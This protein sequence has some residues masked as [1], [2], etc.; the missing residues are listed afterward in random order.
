MFLPSPQVDL[1][2][3]AAVAAVLT[4]VEQRDLDTCIRLNEPVPVQV[5]INS[6]DTSS[7]GPAGTGSGDIDV[8][9]H[10][11]PLVHL[12]WVVPCIGMIPM[13][14]LLKKKKQPL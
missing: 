7:S 3:D 11:N 13:F 5:S 14:I 4:P 10:I 6:N 2:S 8:G 1:I 9:L 12:V